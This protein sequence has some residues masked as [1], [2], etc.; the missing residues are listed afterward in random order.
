M[1]AFAL[2]TSSPSVWCWAAH[3]TSLC[4]ALLCEVEITELSLSLCVKASVVENM[5][6]L[7]PKCFCYIYSQVGPT[8][9]VV[10]HCSSC[11]NPAE[12]SESAALF[13]TL[14]TPNYWASSSTLS[15]GFP[16]ELPR[17]LEESRFGEGRRAQRS[18][19]SVQTSA[20]L[21]T[22]SLRVIK[23]ELKLSDL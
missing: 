1:S 9:L 19:I 8:L 21:Y 14:T 4:L 22:I 3:S 6:T 16:T 11:E 23:C 7:L 17:Q 13:W 12:Q 10:H 5:E 20:F 2:P 18:L 15:C